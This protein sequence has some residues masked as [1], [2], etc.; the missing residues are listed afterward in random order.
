MRV[1]VRLFGAFRDLHDAEQV[2]LDIPEGGTLDDVRNA[3]HAFGS[4]HWPA[5]KPGL[6]Q[7]SAFGSDDAFLHR[8]SPVPADGR[9]V[10][11]P[12][13]SGG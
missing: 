7:K 3:L 6:L 11:L 1:S 12:P 10:V 5:F 8:H 2:E 9:L 13:V 4:A